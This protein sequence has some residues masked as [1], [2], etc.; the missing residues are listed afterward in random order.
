M[1]L[2]DNPQNVCQDVW[3]YEENSGLDFVVWT[4]DKDGSRS[5]TRFNVPWRKIEKSIEHKHGSKQVH[6]K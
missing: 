5:V 1:A 6:S 2:S 4:T 3:Y